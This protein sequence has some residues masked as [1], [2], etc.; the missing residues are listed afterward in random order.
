M[1]TARGKAT[2]VDAEVVEETQESGGRELVNPRKYT[3][4]VVAEV[5]APAWDVEKLQSLK[6]FDEFY[7][8][9]KEIYGEVEEANDVLGTGFS[10][11]ED[12]KLLEKVPLLFVDWTFRQGDFGKYVSAM[13]VAQFPNQGMGKFIINDGGTGICEQLAE[14]QHHRIKKGMNGTGGLMARGG[15]RVSEYPTDINGMPLTSAEV[16]EHPE[17]RKGT[18]R[19]WYIN[20]SG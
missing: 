2:V 15:L 11:I 18:G 12:K 14:Y 17:A 9:T 6:S 7:A 10:L 3:N 5:A 19:T 8:Y 4:A 20:T 1:A 16:A 13:V